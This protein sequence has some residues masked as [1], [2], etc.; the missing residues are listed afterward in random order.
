MESAALV[1]LDRTL[2]KITITKTVKI[3]ITNTQSAKTVTE[4]WQ[5]TQRWTSTINLVKVA[6]SHVA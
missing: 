4:E 3:S 2:P 5:V 1:L 6:A